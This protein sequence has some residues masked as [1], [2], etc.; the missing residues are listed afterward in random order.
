MKTKK[1]LCPLDFSDVSKKLLDYSVEFAQ[2]NKAKLILL[3]AVDHP[4]LY[5]NYEILTITPHEIGDK[6]EKEAQQKLRTIAQEI[7]HIIPVKTIV[8]MGK[9]FFEIIRVAKEIQ[10]DLIIIGSHG[11]GGYRAYVDWKYN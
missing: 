11:R 8:C 5:D 6:L 3:H 1:I 10:S 2:V 4:H 9:P 7:E